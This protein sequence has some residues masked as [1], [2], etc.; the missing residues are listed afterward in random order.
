[1]F[2]QPYRGADSLT[3][4]YTTSNSLN[5]ADYLMYPSNA[6]NLVDLTTQVKTV[7]ATDEKIDLTLNIY[8]FDYTGTPTAVIT[9]T[10]ALAAS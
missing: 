8:G 3:W 5:G 10:V 6:Q 1:M 2:G 7:L 9:D 4:T